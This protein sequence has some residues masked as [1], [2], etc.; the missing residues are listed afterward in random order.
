VPVKVARGNRVAPYSNRTSRRRTASD[1]RGRTRRDRLAPSP[2]VLP[3]EDCVR[4]SGSR[5]SG[6]GWHGRPGG[7]K[8][9][10]RCAQL[11]AGRCAGDDQVSAGSPCRSRRPTRA[12]RWAG[13]AI[14]RVLVTAPAP[15]GLRKRRRERRGSTRVHLCFL[16]GN[17][18][19]HRWR[20]SRR[21][22]VPGSLRVCPF[23]GSPRY[24]IGTANTSASAP[25]WQRQ[26]GRGSSRSRRNFRAPAAGHPPGMRDAGA[27]IPLPARGYRAPLARQHAGAGLPLPARR[28]RAPLA[29]QHA[30]RACPC[31]RVDGGHPWHTRTQEE[32]R[33]AARRQHSC[34]IRSV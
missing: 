15:N 34:R 21:L 22:C 12:P 17:P 7:G 31:P 14:S 2:T 24:A 27:G 25:F 26:F 4:P 30:G 8:G 29:R 33:P 1:R 20:W 3:T 6:A 13:R 16:F 18:A 5:A 32:P 28:W 19:D 11:P 10:R 23:G 9:M